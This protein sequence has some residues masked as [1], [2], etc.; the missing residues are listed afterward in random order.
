MLRQDPGGE[1]AHFVSLAANE[2]GPTCDDLGGQA[3]ALAARLR[4]M[5][6]QRRCDGAEH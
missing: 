1:G 5:R 6:V 2:F 3:P 4:D